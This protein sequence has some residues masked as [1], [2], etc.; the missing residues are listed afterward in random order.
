M[1]SYDQ[2]RQ[3]VSTGEHFRRGNAILTLIVAQQPTAC[4]ATVLLSAPFCLAS[5]IASAGT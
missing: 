2:M 4:A 5:G 1:R 3:R